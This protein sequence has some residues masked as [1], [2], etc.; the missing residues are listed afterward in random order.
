MRKCFW[1]SL[2]VILLLSSVVLAKDIEFWM[3][4][5][6]NEMAKVAEG[7]INSEYTPKS[8]NNVRVIPLA[9]GDYYSKSLLSLASGDTPDIFSL[10]S[11]IADFALRGGLIDL[12]AFKP[13]EYAELEK[14][15]F[16]SIM[17]PFSVKASRFAIPVDVGGNV[18]VYRVDLL[19]EMGMGIP[20]TWDELRSWQPK[21]LAKGKT[22]GFT[23]FDDMW[24]AYTLITQNGGQFFGTDGF[25]SALDKPESIKGFTEFVELFTKHRLPQALVGMEP[26]LRGE[27]LSYIDGLWVYG[28]LSQAAPNLAGK[29]QVGLIPGVNRNGKVHHGSFAGSVLLGISSF[30]KKKEEAWDFLKWFLSEDIQLKISNGIM[31]KSNGWVWLPAN[32]GAMSKVNLPE[33][34]RDVY[35]KQI[36]ACSP[37]PYAVNALVQYRFVTLALQKC[38]TQKADPNEVILE[39]AK[40]MN[41]EMARRKKEY[42][43]FLENVNKK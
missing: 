36:E 13:T 39:A 29:W 10:G 23:N 37:V 6:S 16:T 19:K 2:L 7:Y 34:V 40:S 24:G 11:E 43:R 4:G 42:S 25:S 33:Q 31:E 5:W 1:G 22:F 32:K 41:S 20:E 12:A 30:S 8:G 26:F 14:G 21:V 15:I 9:W 18:G 17:G 3:V 35:Y 27:Q 28:S 38:V